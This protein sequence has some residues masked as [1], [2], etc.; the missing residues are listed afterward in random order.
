VDALGIDRTHLFRRENDDPAEYEALL[1]AARRATDAELRAEAAE[2]R[3]KTLEAS[4][5][6]RDDLIEALRELDED[7]ADEI[8]A[9]A[10]ARRAALSAQEGK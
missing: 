1:R 8:V 5:R 7:R 3:V 9:R 6:F 2:A 4:V 10:H